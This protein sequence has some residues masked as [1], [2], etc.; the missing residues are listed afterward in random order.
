MPKRRWRLIYPRACL[1]DCPVEQ[2][3]LVF[4]MMVVVM[5]EDRLCCREMIVLAVCEIILYVRG[6][7]WQVKLTI[8]LLV[9]ENDRPSYALY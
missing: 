1:V 9:L 7:G 8:R 5:E 6:A 3:F 2:A 4:F